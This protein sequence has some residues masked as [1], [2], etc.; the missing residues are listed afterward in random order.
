MQIASV[1]LW[2]DG[3]LPCDRLPYWC[4]IPDWLIKIMFLGQVE[5]AIRLGIK[6]RFGIMD[7]V[8]K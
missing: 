1:F 5:T 8:H 4:K 7:S 2:G 6:S 3:K